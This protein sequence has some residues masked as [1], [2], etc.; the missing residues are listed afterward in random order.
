MPGKRSAEICP[1]AAGLHASDTVALNAV[2]FRGAVIDVGTNSVKLLVADVRDQAVTPVLETSEQTRLGAGFY[3]SHQLQ[4]ERIDHTARVVGRFA[5][6][7]RELGAIRVRVIATSAAREAKNGADLRAALDTAS[8][9]VTEVISGEQEADWGFAGVVSNPVF[10]GRPLMILD[11]G[12]GSTEVI[13][14]CSG[15]RPVRPDFRQSFPLGSVRYLER[16]RCGTA[17]TAADLASVRAALADYLR[18]EVRA[19]LEQA[20]APLE[21]QTAVGIGGTTAILALIHHRCVQFD[22]ELIEATEFSAPALTE[23]VERLWS[24]PLEERR[25]LPGLPPERADVILF[26]AAIYEAILREFRLTTL[27]ISLRGLRYAALLT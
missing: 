26:G 12:G 10:A 19:A 7:A 16:F 9:I 27:A 18:R 14:G 11:V 20:K 5:A 6:Q 15:P 22:R 25:K 23:L 4:P 21:V 24:L 1:V 13:L 2:E 17:P 8:G 3:D